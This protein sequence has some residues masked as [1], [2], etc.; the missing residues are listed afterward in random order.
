LRSKGFASVGERKFSWKE[1]NL[2]RNGVTDN[3]KKK[4]R[5]VIIRNV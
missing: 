4:K 3:G 2:L 5:A 1:R